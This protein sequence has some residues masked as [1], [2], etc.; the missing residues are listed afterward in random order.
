M[1]APRTIEAPNAQAEKAVGVIAMGR[2]Q[3]AAH[4]Y[5]DCRHIALL[6]VWVGLLIEA[7]T[8]RTE[9]QTK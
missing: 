9:E 1:S 7:M 8:L 4:A 6:W 3:F 5:C 2:R